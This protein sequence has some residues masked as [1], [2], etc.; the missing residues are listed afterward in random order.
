MFLSYILTLFYFC[1]LCN[2]IFGMTL[3]NFLINFIPMKILLDF[4]AH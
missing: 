1:C 4:R 3:D 2:K